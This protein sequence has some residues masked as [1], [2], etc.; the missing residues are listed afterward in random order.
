MCVRSFPTVPPTLNGGVIQLMSFSRFDT[1]HPNQPRSHL[2]LA[3]VCPMANEGANAAAFARNVLLQCSGFASVSFLAV[4]DRASTDDTRQ[5]MEKLSRSSPEIEVIWAP[6]NRGAV[7][8]YIRG[9]REALLRD[10]DWI[11]EI[12]A[13]FSHQ[14]ED[15][16][17]FFDHMDHGY[18]CVFGS[19][20][21]KGGK[22]SQGNTM[23]YLVSRMGT[24][25][26]NVL[27]GT[28]LADMTS[29]FELFS[30]KAL[31][32]VLDRGIRSRAHFFQTEIKVY[33]KNF[34]AVEV[35]IHYKSPSPRMTSSAVTDALLQVTRL[36]ALRLIAQL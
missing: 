23:R 1:V 30:Q 26:S 22:I 3:I 33:C 31:Q 24:V 6:E 2:K 18:D 12:D 21:M 5:H 27:L 11:L 4:I 7:D 10:A 8:A 20:F 19:R 15:I 25:L 29:G 17:Q 9:Y 14:P 28:R 35:P 36:F 13:G 34:N 16:P 32:H